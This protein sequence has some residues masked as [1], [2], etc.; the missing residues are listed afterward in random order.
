[1]SK[2]KLAKASVNFVNNAWYVASWSSELKQQLHAKTILGQPVVLYRLPDGSP[3]AL[4]DLC[5][6]RFLPLSL[7]ELKGDQLQCGYH[8]LTFD[9]TGQCVRVPG[10]ERIPA[11]ARVRNYPVAENMGLVWIWMGD[12]ALADESK[13]F[14]LPQYHESGWGVGYGDAL[15]IATHYLNLADNLCDPAH[16]SFVH[17]TTLGSAAGEDIPVHNERRGNT[18]VTYRWTLDSPPVGFFQVFGNFP[19]HV[20]RWQYYYL[21]APSIA[22]VDFGSADAGSGAPE[23]NRDDC[24]QVF[25]CHFLTPETA[26]TTVD[27]W[28]HV[29]NFAVNDETVSERI[30]EQFR[31][32]FAEDKFIL[33]AVQARSDQFPDREPVK[34]AID[35]GPTR[36]RQVIEEML[37]E[38]ATLI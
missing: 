8:G 4:E 32:A 30:S 24:I 10:Q 29:R 28:L 14:D 12:P 7:G 6:H 20:D 38:E 2:V 17:K 35:A 11:K 5:P 18:I 25:S 3:V 19:G 16:V 9:R 31:I 21:H 27:Y 26:S 1:M 15:P 22:I 36:L 13:I 37:A 23:G 33:E 34:I